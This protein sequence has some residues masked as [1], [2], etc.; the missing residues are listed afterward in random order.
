MYTKSSKGKFNN[1]YLFIY[2]TRM[3]DWSLL[4]KNNT[5]WSYSSIYLF[6]LE[7]KQ[8]KFNLEPMKF[9]VAFR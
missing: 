3:L 7:Y 5:A 2:Y 4:R 8:R 1:I 6:L 9:I